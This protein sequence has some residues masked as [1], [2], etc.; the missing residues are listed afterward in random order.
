MEALG[1]KPLASGSP[2]E[3][4]AVLVRSDKDRLDIYLT[5]L[6]SLWCEKL[7]ATQI[8]ARCQVRFAQRVCVTFHFL[9]L[10]VIAI[11]P[12][13]RIHGGESD[14]AVSTAIKRGQ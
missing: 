6:A 10:S 13:H 7:S 1:W 2:G 3:R 14:P 5:D 12:S 8:L 4:L 11:E 9:S